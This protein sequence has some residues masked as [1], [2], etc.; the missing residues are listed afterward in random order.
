M[1]IARGINPTS[2]LQLANDT[3]LVGKSSL[4]EA[5]CMKSTLDLCSQASGQKNNWKKSEIFFFNTSIEKQQDIST[6]LGNKSR[7]LPSKFL[8]IPLFC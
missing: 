4:C 1:K 8:G 7:A 2:H 6:I 3:L 5:Q